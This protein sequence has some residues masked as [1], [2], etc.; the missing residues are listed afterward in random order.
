MDDDLVS[1]AL[2]DVLLHFPDVVAHIVDDVHADRFWRWPEHFGKCFPSPVRDPLAFVPGKF[3]AAA[4]APPIVEPLLRADR[5]AGKLEVRQVDL[6]PLHDPLAHLDVVRGDLVAEPARSG[7]DHHAYLARLPDPES[8]RG[9]FVVHPVDLLDLHEVVSGAEASDL[10]LS[11]RNGPL[12][13]FRK[14]RVLEAA[15]R[16]DVVGVVGPRVTLLD[17]PAD[18]LGRELREVLPRHFRDSSLAHAAGDVLEA[19][20]R[21]RPEV[22][23]DVGCEEVCPYVPDAAIDIVYDLSG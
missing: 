1:G 20:V 4:H 15:A 10:V 23:T 9:P 8:F 18:A 19:R 22:R 6:L 11:A 13:D 21:Q 5:R 7:V 12:A 17:R 16:L 3:C 14:V 2:D